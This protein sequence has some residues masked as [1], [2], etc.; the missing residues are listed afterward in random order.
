MI[1]NEVSRWL[2]ME[3]KEKGVF[4]DV[5]FLR[6]LVANGV[7]E[8]GNVAVVYFESGHFGKSFLSFLI[9]H[10]C[11]VFRLLQQVNKVAYCITNGIVWLGPEIKSKNTLLKI[12]MIEIKNATRDKNS[13]K[14][15]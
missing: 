11:H 12:N 4:S 10:L 1:K 8:C 7:D 9:F 5:L 14:Y 2:V 15:T 13:F 3:K 6:H